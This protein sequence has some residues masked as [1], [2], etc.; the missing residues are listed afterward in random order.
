[1]SQF[2]QSQSAGAYQ[3]P[4]ASTSPYAAPP[5]AGYPTNDTSHA[6]MAPVETKSKGDGF[7]K[8][9]YVFFSSSINF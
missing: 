7:W 8:G 9:W 4:P 3:T 6:T 2:S 1:M 5:P